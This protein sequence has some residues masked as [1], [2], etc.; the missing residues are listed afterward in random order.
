MSMR[1]TPALLQ[2]TADALSRLLEPAGPAD[3]LLHQYFREQRQLGQRERAFVAET[4]FGVLRHLLTLRELLGKRS[5]RRF[6]L[7]YLARWGGTSL[8]DLEP[9]LRGDEAQWL[10]SLKATSHELSLA[11]RTELP[12]WLLERMLPALGEEEIL[13]LGRALQQPAPMDLRVNLLRARRE[14][15]LARLAADGIEARATPYSP[16]GVRLADRPAIN[17]HPLYLEGAVE[18]QDE[19]SQLLGWLTAPHRGEMVVD[20]CAGAG[21]KTLVMGAL[22]QSLGRLYAFDV[23]DKRLAGLK[24]RL[25]RSG[26]SNVHPQRIDSENDAKVKRL[27]GKIDRVLVDAPCSGFGTLRRN[28]DFK[29]RQTPQSVAELSAKQAAILEGAARL[30]KPGGRL[31]YATCSF[32][33]E[34]NESVVEGFLAR[35]PD[36]RLLDCAAL[37]AEQKIPLDTGRYLRLL[38]HR[39]GCD[40]F[41]AAA[42]ERSQ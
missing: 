2:A 10:A 22:M 8:R 14:D 24:P 35:H 28:P 41:F 31:V 19:G 7:A 4:C 13:A 25:K 6:M 23:S 21:G 17:R 38:P 37:L 32:L 40:G 29:I 20:F 1:L 30:P 36:Y 11:A 42:L 5:P 34:E 16:A 39:H 9:C 15:V 27:A 26:L 18:V 3:A 33:P 12:Q